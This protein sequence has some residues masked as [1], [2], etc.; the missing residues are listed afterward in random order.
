ARKLYADGAIEQSIEVY[1]DILHKN[2]TCKE[3]LDELVAHAIEIGFFDIAHKM[4]METTRYY[5]QSVNTL[6]NWGFYHQR[7]E[8]YEM[9]AVFLQ[10]VL[11]K[12]PNSVTAKY[13]LA[14]LKETEQPEK[15]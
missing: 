3:A 15:T 12:D 1:L 13:F 5:P 7:T 2:P 8:Q 9:A 10:T 11:K 14:T 6:L 4:L